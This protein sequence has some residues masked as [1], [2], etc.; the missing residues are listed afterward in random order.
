[1]VNEAES[2]DTYRLEIY[3]DRSV[4]NMPDGTSQVFMEGSPNRDARERLR[5][6]KEKFDSGFLE[7]LIQECKKPDN[8]LESLAPKITDD[9]ERLVG[10]VTSEVGRALVGVTFL[11]FA[12]KAAVPDQSIRLHKGG[13]TG[14]NFSWAD[15]IPMRVLDKQYCTPL[16]REY[17]LLKLNADGVFMTRSLAENYPYSRLYKAAMRGARTE[18]LRIVDY[19]ETGELDPLQGIKL[20]IALLINH[21]NSFIEISER[22]LELAKAWVDRNP[23]LEEST[24]FIKAYTDS[25]SH[26][27][28]LFEV[29]LHSCYQVFEDNTLL[30]GP[31]KPLSQMRSANKKHGDIGDI[32]I[33]ERVGGLQ[34]IES[35][36]AKYGKPYLRDELEE[37]SDKLQDHPETAIAGF[38]VDNNPDM[39]QEI[40]DRVN[41]LKEIH[42]TTV[43]I[44]DFE[45]WVNEM[46]KR[47]GID[48][49]LF[50]KKWVLAFTESLCQ[51]RRDRAPIDE[52]CNVWVEELITH[53]EKC[54]NG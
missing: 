37:L 39:R 45:T 33:V 41:E 13:G 8:Q 7:S 4:L 2:E 18:W 12:I 38:V 47:F 53:F 11:Q 51:K 23:T 31:L 46:V 1:M 26:S 17:D 44:T 21:S 27:A 3:E 15:G 10:K 25:S 48:K 16:L 49:P 22:A 52:P 35:W 34:V 32:E 42:G 24:N 5:Q 30:E 54:R 9:L 14:S 19:I 50:A 29:A 40:T 6:V 43:I 36:D 20:L 28:R